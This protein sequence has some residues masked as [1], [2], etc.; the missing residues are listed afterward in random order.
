MVLGLLPV[1]VFADLADSLSGL[2][3]QS[4]GT[5]T[6]H[7][8]TPE[9]AILNRYNGNDQSFYKKL[10]GNTDGNESDRAKYWQYNAVTLFTNSSTW[11]TAQ[12][13][14]RATDDTMWH[15]AAGSYTNGEEAYSHSVLKQLTKPSKNLEVGASATFYNRTHTHSNYEWKK[16]RTWTVDLTR[17]ESLS[18]GIGGSYAPAIGGNLD[19]SRKYP[20]VGNFGDIGSGY[21]T[22]SYNESNNYCRLH[23]YPSTHKWFDFE[24]R[25]CTCSVYAENVLVTFRDTRSPR[26]QSPAPPPP[27]SRRSR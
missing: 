6:Y 22:L 19:K 3:V 14:D 5:V 20:R 1:S 7:R 21:K 10:I 15:Y 11:K 12:Y 8:K 17:F 16:V 4:A 13:R 24:D 26:P 23:F 9:V 25:E 2:A 27:H 18:V